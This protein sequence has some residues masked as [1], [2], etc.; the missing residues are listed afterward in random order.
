MHIMYIQLLK[1]EKFSQAEGSAH[2]RVHSH[3]LFLYST[4]GQGTVIFTDP[5]AFQ[6]TNLLLLVVSN[7]HCAANTMNQVK[8]PSSPLGYFYFLTYF[9]LPVLFA[10][11]INAHPFWLLLG[12]CSLILYPQSSTPFRWTRTDAFLLD[13]KPDSVSACH[14]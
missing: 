14:F 4:S 1:G 7:H 6:R 12:F 11:L 13:L 9:P 8:I 5:L 3:L 10:F 2:L